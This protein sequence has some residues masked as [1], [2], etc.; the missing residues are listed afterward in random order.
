MYFFV[1]K[2]PNSHRSSSSMSINPSSVTDVLSDR[3]P[4]DALASDSIRPRQ[5]AQRR[6]WML[7]YCPPGTYITAEMLLEHRIQA[8][9]VHS[10]A[11]RVMNYTYVHLTKKVRRTAMEAFL[12]AVRVSH[13]VIQSEV[14]GYDS[15]VSEARGG[16]RLQDHVV[17]MMLAKHCMEKEAS[18]R[19]WTDGQPVLVRGPLFQAVSGPPPVSVARMEL[20]TRRQLLEHVTEL[21]RRLGDLEARRA[22]QSLEFTSLSD[23]FL[24][25]RAQLWAEN[26]VLRERVSYLE[27][28]MGLEG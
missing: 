6:T 23:A 28:A 14:F 20:W 26:Q 5:E 7:T 13:G 8:D 2:K 11:D 4:S 17:F 18:F 9:E 22:E 24:E 19:P 27:E 3:S 12:R 10:T 16:E 1:L 25:R 21:Q 15:L